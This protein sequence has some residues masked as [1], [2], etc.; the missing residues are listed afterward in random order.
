MVRLDGGR[1]T[2]SRRLRGRFAS[3]REDFMNDRTERARHIAA[4]IKALPSSER[5]SAIAWACSSDA[6]LRRE[7]DALM[8]P[9]A[10]AKGATPAKAV[11]G[12]V[13][14][15]APAKRV[16]PQ[17]DA[18]HEDETVYDPRAK[19]PSMATARE[20]PG[21]MIGP[22]TLTRQ[23]GSGGFGVV[24][25]ADQ[26]KPV[27]RKVAIKII[28]LGMD[29]EQ[30]VRR[31]EQE[32]QAVALMGHPNIAKFFDAGT[33]ESG[34]PFFVM[35]FVPGQS[36]VKW[37]DKTRLSIAKRLGLFV[38]VCQAIQHAHSKGVIHRDIKPSNVLV[39]LQDGKPMAKVIDF[40]IAKATAAQLSDVSIHTEA[41][42][43]VGTPEYMSPEQAMGSAD[44]DTR[45]D[46]YSLGVLLYELLTGSLPFDAKT[47]RSG[48][49][50]ELQRV[51]RE[52]E[53][54]KPSTRIATKGD[55][56]KGIALNRQVDPARLRSSLSGELDWIV[57][58][59]LE[60]DRGRRYETA[61]GLAMDIHRHLTGDEV[62]AAPPGA[63]YRVRKFVGR[64]RGAVATAALVVVALVL[65]LAGTVWKSREAAL[66]RDAAERA[67]AKADERAQDIRTILDF[68]GQMLR[69]VDSSAAGGRLM[70][71]L[72]RRLVASLA[73]SGVST[74]EQQRQEEVL[75]AA[76]DR[77]N[78]TDAATAFLDATVLK[79]S[80]EGIGSAF[81]KQPLI[82][83]Q[84]RQSLG[85]RYARI[86]LIEQAR[87]LV[88]DALATRHRELGED[89][90]DTFE[91]AIYLCGLLQA[92]GK[93]AE[94]EVQLRRALERAR[95][96][97]GEEHLTT[98]SAIESMG[99]LLSSQGNLEEAEEHYGEALRRYR[100]LLGD[101]DPTTL[102]AITGMA[103]VLL[104]QSKPGE[105]EPLVVEG[106]KGQQQ[107][108]GADHPGT[109]ASLSQFGA[110]LR[111]KGKL[112]DAEVQFRDALER[113]KR[114]NGDEHRATVAAASDLANLL[115]EQRNAKAAEP[116]L[117][118]V[119][120]RQRRILGASHRATLATTANLTALLQSKG[121]FAE[122]VR[123]AIASLDGRQRTLGADHPDTLASVNALGG[124]L[125]AQEK[126]P[127][128]EKVLADGVARQRRVLGDSHPV[129]LVGIHQLGVTLQR[130]R[131]LRECVDLVTPFLGVARSARGPGQEAL[132]ADLLVLAA[133]S[134]VAMGYDA[135]KFSVA[136]ADLLDGYRMLTTARGED[137]P[138]TREC[139]QG[140]VDLY[141]AIEKRTPGL[142]NA[143]KAAEWRTKV[144]VRATG[145]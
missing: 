40:G 43:L 44:I 47:L 54:A 38:T 73:A 89:H 66:E 139:A 125:V 110:L 145:Q 56:L 105:A 88:S 117:R 61:N 6:E 31:F 8:R 98:L 70:D 14:S 24:F 48:A 106:L 63:A 4:R 109:L 28:K 55:D 46:V 72:K 71:D 103:S 41:K 112:A 20:G 35:E 59:C 87:V 16:A 124:L 53:P 30:V 115:W 75:A 60:K 140:L 11:A 36:I 135:E 83:A 116:L 113:N 119:L 120:E 133:T 90:P 9:S 86:G 45:T 127:Q 65:G 131:K 122:A 126:F 81:S 94:A 142:G 82:A 51:I 62:H 29:S 123:M 22:Y 15:A 52:V 130:Q 78:A 57:M 104:A 79:P 134:R 85:D 144:Q 7:V 50:A 18:R 5:A 39:Y 77:I 74:A 76:L 12:E 92:Q 25:E 111:A 141:E 21:T 49:Y 1:G 17:S 68:Q 34:R 108:L 132:C 138:S 80:V 2:I 102:D 96:V 136:E 107:V 42:Q 67:A 121:A 32:R 26:S 118:D 143:A 95:T 84:L 19:I 3:G 129:T 97:L 93:Y 114:V 33:T 69:Q 37:C 27:R 128:A 137:H 91:S 58:R 100:F 101:T 13:K 64:H 99:V 10:P 23:L